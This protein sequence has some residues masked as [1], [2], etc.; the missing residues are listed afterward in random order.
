LAQ[1]KGDNIN[2]EGNAKN[3]FLR[4]LSYK[5]F[6]ADCHGF[7]A[8]LKYKFFHDPVKRASDKKP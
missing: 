3:S 2:Q 6:C 1:A 4:T 5:T 7:E 8:L